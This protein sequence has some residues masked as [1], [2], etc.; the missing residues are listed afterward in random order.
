M[1]RWWQWPPPVWMRLSRVPS[2][3]NGLVR[4]V[5]TLV[6]VPL[7]FHFQMIFPVRRTKVVHQMQSIK[8]VWGLFK[9][10]RGNSSTVVVWNLFCRILK[11]ACQVTGTAFGLLFGVDN[12]FTWNIQFFGLLYLL[13]CLFDFR[14]FYHHNIKLRYLWRNWKYFHLV[15]GKKLL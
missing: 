3:P 13:K 12:S 9:R 5:L 1:G 10:S 11:F 15:W 8:M 6:W 14:S 4:Q 2:S 7:Y